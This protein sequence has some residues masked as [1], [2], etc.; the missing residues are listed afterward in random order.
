M[1]KSGRLLICAAVLAGAVCFYGCSGDSYDDDP[2]WVKTLTIY[3]NVADQDGEPLEGATVWVDG[4]SVQNRTDDDYRRLGNRF[5][6]DW[7]G[8]RYNWSGG[9]FRFDVRDCYADICTIEI[10]VSKTGWETQ[11]TSITFD[12]WDPDDIS[13]RQTF[14][15]EPDRDV[16]S[17]AAVSDAPEPPELISLSDPDWQG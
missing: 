17:A 4:S 3:L 7:R 14:V 10:L 1:P 16:R 5:P 8:W 15:M 6:P 11:R 13:M 12:R 9:P 2:S